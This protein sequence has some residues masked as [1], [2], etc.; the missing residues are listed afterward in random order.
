[1][2][3]LQTPMGFR[4][5]HMLFLR[6]RMGFPQTRMPFLRTRML[7]PHSRTGSLQLP[8]L[9]RRVH[10]PFV[11]TRMGL[12]HTR[13]GLLRTRMHPV[14]TR[15][16]FS[17]SPPHAYPPKWV[18]WQCTPLAYFGYVVGATWFGTL[19]QGALARGHPLSIAARW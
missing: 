19:W 17:R 18:L 5:K 3:F 14:Q 8:L 2:L 9:L 10:V 16:H 4:K 15:M 1:M 12:P 11:R 13:M 6:T 7:L